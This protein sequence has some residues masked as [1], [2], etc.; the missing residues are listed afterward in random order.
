MLTNILGGSGMNSRLNLVLREK[1]GY[2][3]SIGSQFVPFTD[4]GLFVISFGTDP[5][6]LKKSISL[7]KV[8]LSK[9]R[10]ERL[11]VKQLS[12]SKEQL[13][14]HL[15]MAQ[16]SNISY[17]IMMA[18]NLLDMGRISSFEEIQERIKETTAIQLQEL[19]NEIFV[20]RDLS[21]LVMLPK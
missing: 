14:G 20:E 15:A 9:M 18:R 11:G 6:Q 19:A 8:E 12:A 17:M 13:L 1:H 5:S 7:V 10:H 21:C 2:V 3:Y 16:E 4:S